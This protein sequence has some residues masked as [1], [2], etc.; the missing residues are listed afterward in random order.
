M[1]LKKRLKILQLL[2][3]TQYWLF[4]LLRICELLLFP[5]ESFKNGKWKF[6][7]YF[8]YEYVWSGL[9][10][11]AEPKKRRKLSTCALEGVVGIDG[12]AKNQHDIVILY[13]IFQGDLFYLRAEALSG[14]FHSCC[15]ARKIYYWAS[16]P[17][18]CPETRFWRFQNVGSLFLLGIAI[19]HERGLVLKFDH[20]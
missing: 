5:R 14:C 1:R 10:L 7:N 4:E 20:T 17:Y 18:T 3:P 16:P 11:R 9:L 2:H 8:S 12:D 19:F 15:S 13:Y 6:L